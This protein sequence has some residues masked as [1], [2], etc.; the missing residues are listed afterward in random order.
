[1]FKLG[2]IEWVCFI[3]L[4]IGGINYG[5]IGVVGLDLI[6]AIFGHILGSLIAIVICLAA[7]YMIYM[8]WVWRK[9]KKAEGAQ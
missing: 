4:L 5:I 6:R 1:M 7:V 2:K 3:L 9:E 8:I